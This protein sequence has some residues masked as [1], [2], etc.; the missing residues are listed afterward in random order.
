MYYVPK[1]PELSQPDGDGPCHG[2]GPVEVKSDLGRCRRHCP[3]MS[4]FPVMFETDWCG[5]HKLESVPLS[6]EEIKLKATADYDKIMERQKDKMGI[7]DHGGEGLKPLTPADI[8]VLMKTLSL[9]KI[10]SSKPELRIV[11]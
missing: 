3:T 4:G 2:Q 1:A 7:A 11:D 5:D 10:P 9:N 6:Q 8:G